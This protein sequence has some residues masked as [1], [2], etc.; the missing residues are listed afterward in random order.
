MNNEDSLLSNAAMGLLTHVLGNRRR[1][2][3]AYAV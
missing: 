2:H 3:V 1:G